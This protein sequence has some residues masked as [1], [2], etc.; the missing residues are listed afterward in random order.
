[1]A[2][3]QFKLIFKN[4]IYI[5]PELNL[6]FLKIKSGDDKAKKQD[7]VHVPAINIGNEK[8]TE[9]L[10]EKV[11]TRKSQREREAKLK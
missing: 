7:A 5:N 4:M 11:A 6:F 9:A 8:R 10:R 2:P 1:M 3:H